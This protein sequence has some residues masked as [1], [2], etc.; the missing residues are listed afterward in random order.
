MLTRF[1]LT[2]AETITASIRADID[3]ICAIMPD[4][5]PVHRQL[6]IGLDGPE[7]LVEIVA[8]DAGLTASILRNVNSAAF[9]LAFPIVSV[10]HA[11]TYLGVSM[12]KA[13]VAQAAVAQRITPGT[14]AQEAALRRVWTSAC[15]ASAIAQLL[16]QELGLSRP[17]V[18]AT[19][20]LFS[21]LGDVALVVAR[22]ESASWYTPGFDIVDRLNHQQ[23]AF[24][25]NSAMVGAALADRWNLPTDI[26][27]AIRM[28][29]DPLVIPEENPPADETHG[30]NLLLYLAARIGDRVSYMGLQDI[31]DL[32]LSNNNDP[33]IFYLVN[34]LNRPDL[35]K[36]L[37]LF[38]DVAFRRKANLIVQTLIGE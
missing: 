8:S 10:R 37:A 6:G 29:F 4:P 18:L 22:P 27:N 9:S 28:G 38:E 12:V 11:I 36:V 26:S 17:S 3:A 2:R 7:E 1:E 34:Q 32:D 15:G 35:S 23:Q 20:A 30:D 31:A 14:P 13:M 33:D 25:F 21:N 16:A 24:G 19:R 5:H